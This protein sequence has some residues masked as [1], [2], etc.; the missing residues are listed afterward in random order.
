MIAFRQSPTYTATALVAF[1]SSGEKLDLDPRFI[2]TNISR[3]FSAVPELALSDEVLQLLQSKTTPSTTIPNLRVLLSAKIGEDNTIFRFSAT[4]ES[5][6]TA[7]TLANSWANVFVPWANE[8]YGDQS[9]ERMLFFQ[10]QLNQANESLNQVTNSWIEFKSL[11]RTAIISDTL[12]YNRETRL[13][14]LNKE[15]DLDR[16]QTNIQALKN[17]V[18]ELPNNQSVSF[19]N[20][21]AFLQLQSQLFNDKEPLA[22]IFQAS[23]E[24]TLLTNDR[25]EFLNI[26]DITLLAIDNQR[27]QLE[28]EVELIE[29]EILS[30]QQ[31]QEKIFAE[32]FRLH[33]ELDISRQ[34]VLIL[35]SKVEEERIT[36]N[37]SSVG[38]RVLSNAAIPMVADSRNI[39]LITLMA[40]VA[41]ASLGTGI[42]VW[43][44]WREQK[45]ISAQ[46]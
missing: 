37:D 34:T 43:L 20:Q 32:L 36:S 11:D 3:P 24:E 30:L 38:F 15:Q 7:S 6:K 14:F 45:N 46:T 10:N 5:P 33:K 2:N 18:L 44:A 27:T 40:L 4:S 8:A 22:Y 42:V 17:Q 31:E 12:G 13:Q 19:A 25:V 41:G 35:A 21:L 1:I 26:I 16:L 39:A 9:N 28:S 29:P 23:G